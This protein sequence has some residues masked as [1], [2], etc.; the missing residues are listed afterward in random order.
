MIAVLVTTQARHLDTEVSLGADEGLPR[1]CVANADNLLTFDK[2]LL[3]DRPGALSDEKLAALD[4]ALRY[5]LGLERPS[6]TAY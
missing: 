2:A 4:D 1:P 6:N 3:L 5:A